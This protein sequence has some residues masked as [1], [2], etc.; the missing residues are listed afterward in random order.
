MKGCEMNNIAS[1]NKQWIIYDAKSQVFLE[2]NHK[3][4]KDFING[5]DKFDPIKFKDVEILNTN[6]GKMVWIDGLINA[7]HFK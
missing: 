7:E 4:F 3:E 2:F 1:E 6:K 5:R